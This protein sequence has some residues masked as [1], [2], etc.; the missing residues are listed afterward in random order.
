MSPHERYVRALRDAA[1]AYEEANC[2]KAK[3]RRRRG[4]LP[5][6]T[7][8]AIPDDIRAKVDAKLLASGYRPR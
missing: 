3:H 8:R 6:S 4:L 2:G 7:G 1:D 5:V